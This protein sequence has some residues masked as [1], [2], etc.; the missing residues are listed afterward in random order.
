VIILLR[1]EIN[2]SKNYIKILWFLALKHYWYF[3]EQ[4]CFIF[5]HLLIW[6]FS[7][8]YCPS[9]SA[10]PFCGS[11]FSSA[12]YEYLQLQTLWWESSC[13]FSHSSAYLSRKTQGKLKLTHECTLFLSLNKRTYLKIWIL[14]MIELD[15]LYLFNRVLFL[16]DVFSKFF[17]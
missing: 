7:Q 3:G 12:S 4:V 8:I 6:A 14:Q 2:Q 17:S 5:F 15:L 1:T 16:D 13:I 10:P 11:Y 9:I